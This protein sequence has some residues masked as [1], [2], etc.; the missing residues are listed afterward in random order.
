MNAL[1]NQIGTGAVVAHRVR[2]TVT[3]TRGSAH[4]LLHGQWMP[5][6]SVI[7]IHCARVTRFSLS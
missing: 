3:L 1:A 7:W 2:V 4:F 5:M 6:L